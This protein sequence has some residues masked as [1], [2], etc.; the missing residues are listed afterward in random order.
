MGV[1]LR[2]YVFVLFCV[3]VAALRRL[4]PPSNESYRL[5]IGLRNWKSGQGPTKDCRAIDRERERCTKPSLIKLIVTQ[6]LKKSSPPRFWKVCSQKHATGPYLIQMSSV[7]ILASYFFK[8]Q[9]NNNL[10]STQVVNY[11]LI[12]A[13]SR[14][15]SEVRSCGICG[16]Q[17]ALGQVYS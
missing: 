3:Y 14:V 1:C 11:W 12:I 16:G 10:C 5:C 17:V 9:F 13:V 7:H 2:Y 6:L 15:R 4:D 8:V